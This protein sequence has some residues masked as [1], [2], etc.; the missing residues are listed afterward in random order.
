MSWPQK[1]ET[2]G[3][4]GQRVTPTVS[5]ESRDN[6]SSPGRLLCPLCLLG[7]LTQPYPFMS[8]RAC[9]F[10][11]CG[12]TK[13]CSLSPLNAPSLCSLFEFLL[14]LEFPQNFDWGILSA[15]FGSLAD[16]RPVPWPGWGILGQRF[17]V[18]SCV[19]QV[20]CPPPRTQNR[21]DQPP[22]V[23]GFKMVPGLVRTPAHICGN[24]TVS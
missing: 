15:S 1:T 20:L 23:R 2:R 14:W 18:F 11:S 4:K 6:R 9:A 12:V 21:Q 19:C 13:V 3:Q 16:F 8:V 7:H 5:G 10:Q 22:T 17:S 24:H